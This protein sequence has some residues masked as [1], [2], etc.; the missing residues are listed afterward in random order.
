MSQSDE[1]QQLTQPIAADT[2]TS[3]DAT[4]STGKRRHDLDALR[5]FAMLLGIGLHASL[6]FFPGFW[7]VTDNKADLDAGYD[8]FFLAVHGFRMPLFFLLSGFFTV[9]VWRRRGMSSLLGQ[10]VKRIAVPLAIGVVTIVPLVDWVVERA[11]DRPDDPGT[12]LFV[13][14]AEGDSEAKLRALKAGADLDSRGEDGGTF[15]HWAAFMGDPEVVRLLLEAGAD[16]TVVDYANNTPVGSTFVFGNEEAAD[17]L[18]AAGAPD[19]RVGGQ[20]W[21]DV[22]WWAF[23]A[24]DAPKTDETA[25]DD[26]FE[27]PETWIASFH[28]L[29]FLWFLCL[30]VV[31]FVVVARIVEF[32]ERSFADRIPLDR[33]AWTVMWLLVPFTFLPQLRMGEWGAYPTFGPDT[34]TA[35]VPDFH[36]L[37]Y[38]AV[39]FGFGALMY[40]RRNRAG[41][42][43][44]DTIGRHWAVLLPL[45]VIIVLPIALGVTYADDPIWPVAAALQVTFTWAMIVGLM[46]LSRRFL[47]VERPGVRYLSDSAYWLYLMHL[48]LVIAGQ[49]WVRDWDLPASLKF[50]GIS[51]V[52]TA[53]LLASYQLFVR[54]TPIGWIL[55]GPRTPTRFDLPWATRAQASEVAETST[56]HHTR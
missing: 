23:G 48:P 37:A 15:L 4:P 50:F 27:G 1:Q 6:S 7:A 8:E 16:P 28:H 55:N 19:P 38:Y 2:M 14:I 30:F 41:E 42:L 45:T 31:G 11:V 51:L 13:A 46:G 3:P 26:G 32:L 56:P 34:S 9:M 40:D 12:A 18:V 20:D 47:A 24:E 54:Y 35:L 43:L 22:P 5:G 33:V 44:V 10:R 25:D 39:F 29:W 36:V 53:I 52:A 21:D 17:L 49:D